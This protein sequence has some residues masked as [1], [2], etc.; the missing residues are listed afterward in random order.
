MPW[1]MLAKMPLLISSRITSAGLTPSMSARSLTV[2]LDGSSI[3]PRSRRSP[4]GAT[5]GTPLSRRGGLRGPRRPRVPLLLLATA[6]SFFD[7]AR[8]PGQLGPE[9]GRDGH[10]KRTLQRTS[11]K[12]HPAAL[13][14]VADI[15]A[16][17]VHLAGRIQDHAAIRRPHDPP[18]VALLPR[19][20]TDDA[21]SGR[22]PPRRRAP[23]YGDTSPSA[24]GA[25]GTALRRLGLASAAA[26]SGAAGTALRRLGLAG[27]SCVVPAAP[28]PAA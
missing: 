16:P 14:T 22:K 12:C 1:L 2:M 27:A 6:V 11:V 5:P 3:A 26:G 18:Q 23:G 7:L 19:R 8:L 15:G 9:L 4:T 13:I 20:A 25:A 28:E 10:P 24:A 21:G 17:A